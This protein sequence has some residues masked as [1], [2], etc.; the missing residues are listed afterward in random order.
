MVRICNSNSQEKLDG[1]TVREKRTVVAKNETNE[2][3]DSPPYP[4][5][6]INKLSRKKAQERLLKDIAV[7]L[8]ICEME[9]W[10]KTE[11]INE[12]IKLINS[13]KPKQKKTRNLMFPSL[14]DFA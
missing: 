13:L 3:D 1:S 10:D 14:F 2:S 11:Y 6:V 8:V 5:A 4:A 7:D 12:L 9:G